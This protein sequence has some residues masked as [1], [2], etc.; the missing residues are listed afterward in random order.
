MGKITFMVDYP[1]G[2]EPAVSADSDIT[3]GKVVSLAFGDDD[4]ESNNLLIVA[5]FGLKLGLSWKF[6]MKLM[7]EGRGWGLHHV[8][9]G[10]VLT[11]P[12]WQVS[13]VRAVVREIVPV[14][15]RIDVVAESR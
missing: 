13:D 10:E 5:R 14:T 4:T 3:W 8:D 9:D 11:V 15:Y 2:Q 6:V 12:S 7:M 1:D